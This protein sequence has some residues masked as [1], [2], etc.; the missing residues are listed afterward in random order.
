MAAQMESIFRIKVSG[1]GL[2]DVNGNYDVC[3]S[4]SKYPTIPTIEKTAG[5]HFRHKPEFMYVHL[6][7]KQWEYAIYLQPIP[8][9]GFDVKKSLWV[10]ARI[11]VNN[12]NKTPP[13][14]LYY[15]K[16]RNNDN[17][18]P[19]NGWMPIGG[20]APTPKTELIQLQIPKKKEPTSPLKK[21]I[22]EANRDENKMAEIMFDLSGKSNKKLGA[23]AKNKGDNKGA[24]VN[25]L[26]SN[27]RRTINQPGSKS[28]DMRRVRGE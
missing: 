23:M 13:I 22:E 21:A 16:R 5:N 14:V 8:E 6:S 17:V 10:L 3:D 11:N 27:P 28:K 26:I 15:A 20:I 19:P 24:G 25:K 7:H 9:M 12:D 18:P 1:A 2:L 4:I